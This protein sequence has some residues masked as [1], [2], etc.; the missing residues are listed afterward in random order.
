MLGKIINTKIKLFKI[1]KENKFQNNFKIKVN[2]LSF[3]NSFTIYNLMKI[4]IFKLLISSNI[5]VKNHL[6]L[7]N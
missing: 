2:I 7:T 3:L 5:P 6:L 1:F 4:L